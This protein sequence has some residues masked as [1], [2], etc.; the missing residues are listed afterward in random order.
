M[1][2]D[3][4]INRMNMYGQCYANVPCDDH[5]HLGLWGKTDLRLQVISS[6][7]GDPWAAAM[8]LCDYVKGRDEDAMRRDIMDLGRDF[9]R[10]FARHIEDCDIRHALQ[11]LSTQ[12]KDDEAGVALGGRAPDVDKA[13]EA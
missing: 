10:G 3:V 5:V 2:S 6:V 4:V 11:G 1:V 9:Q 8:W 13:P 7:R 12:D